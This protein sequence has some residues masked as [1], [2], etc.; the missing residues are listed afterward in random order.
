MMVQPIADLS[1][2]ISLV[3]QHESLGRKVGNVPAKGIDGNE[4]GSLE[5]ARGSHFR[6]FTNEKASAMSAAMHSHAVFL[7]IVGWRILPE[8]FFA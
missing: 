5:Q 3:I 7:V 2:A 8:V 4:L 1:N 6:Y